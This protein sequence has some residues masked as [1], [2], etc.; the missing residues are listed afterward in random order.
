MRFSHRPLE[1]GDVPEICDFP[2]SE[3]ELYFSFPKAQYPLTPE[4]LKDAADKRKNP[5]VVILDG[6]VVGYA[7]F[8]KVRP[9]IFCTLGNLLVHPL[10]RRQGVATYLV[11]TMIRIAVETYKARFVRAACFSHNSAGYQFYRGMGFKPAD[12]V[13]RTTP[14]GET[15]LLVNM[16]LICKRN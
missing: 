8:F 4:Q 10:H 7:N 1:D 12:M 13:H 16:E 5:S 3:E 9:D 11:Q 14:D 2:Q 6:K 15:V